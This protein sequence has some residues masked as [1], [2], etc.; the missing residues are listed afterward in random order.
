M[1]NLLF[2]ILAAFPLMGSPGPVTMSLA[3]LGSASGFRPGLGYLCGFITG[4]IAVLSKRGSAAGDLVNCH[5]SLAGLYRPP[6]AQLRR[7][8]AV[9]SWSR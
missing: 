7:T 5:W 8:S 6:P 2:L 9:G 4:T 1:E 3:G